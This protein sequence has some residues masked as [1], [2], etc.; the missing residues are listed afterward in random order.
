MDWVVE[1]AQQASA[2]HSVK[3]RLI[4]S[5][6]RHESLD[7]AEQVIDLAA[8]RIS[9]GIVAVDLAGDEA[10][11]SGLEFSGLFKEARQSG[12]HVTVHAGEWSG[13]SNIRA[14][15]L[16]LSAERI[17]HGVRILEDPLV[18]DLAKERN[19]PLEVC[20]T[21]NLQ[22]GVFPKSSEHPLPQLLAQ[23]LDATINTDDP[24]ISRIT[25]GSEFAYAYQRLHLSKK[26]LQDRV[27]AAARAAFLP[28]EEKKDL[29]ETLLTDLD[30]S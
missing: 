18:V 21:S 10:N 16:Q 26:V 15:I 22:S 7:L 2:S 6:N 8:D 30:V 13:A 1:A 19:I 9:K 23:G 24:S 5:L 25:L 11:F 4:A 12:L 28:Q 29:L 17:G 27:L 14:A 20:I 3:T